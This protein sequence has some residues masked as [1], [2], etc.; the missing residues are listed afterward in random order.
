M[1]IS[2]ETAAA[3]IPS[4]TA[5]TTGPPVRAFVPPAGAA[6]RWPSLSRGLRRPDA[7]RADAVVA[8]AAGAPPPARSADIA[9][10][11][12]GGSFF[13][14]SAHIDI[15]G[16]MTAEPCSIADGRMIMPHTSQ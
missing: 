16:S 6:A 5:F 9:S 1:P 11:L 12:S 2:A 4:A 10:R 13:R 8:V 3:P 15:V 14:H 7:A